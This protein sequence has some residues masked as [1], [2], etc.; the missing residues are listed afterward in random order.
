MA[1]VHVI[2]LGWCRVSS[3][4]EIAAS[5]RGSSYVVLGVLDDAA[6]KLQNGAYPLSS[7]E[8]IM[9]SSSGHVH[10]GTRRVPYGE[11]YGTGDVVGVTVDFS[12]KTISFSVNGRSFGAAASLVTSSVAPCTWLGPCCDFEEVVNERLVCSCGPSSGNP[13]CYHA[14]ATAD[15]QNPAQSERR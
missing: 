3:R 2:G 1:V 5:D 15:F 13:E 6:A 8:G 12:A 9:F 10:R 7:L 4:S 14:V 11:P